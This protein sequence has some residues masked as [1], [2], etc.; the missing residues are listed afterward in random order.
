MGEGEVDGFDGGGVAG[1]GELWT[2]GE[3]HIAD[4][5]IAAEEKFTGAS[6]VD[7]AVAGGD[8]AGEVET[9]EASVERDVEDGRAAEL[10]Q[11]EGGGNGVR[12]GEKGDGGGGGAVVEEDAADGVEG[13]DGVGMGELL[14]VRE[15][16]YGCRR[17]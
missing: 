4:E 8:A 5:G 12:A 1:E 6:E 16:A 11:D 2:G 17:G 15:P 3:G 7:G 13:S 14:K 10:L 9:P